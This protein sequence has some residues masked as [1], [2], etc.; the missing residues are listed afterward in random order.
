MVQAIR[1]LYGTL[2]HQKSDKGILV[3]TSGVTEGVIK[4]IKGKPL[5]ILDIDRILYL[6]EKGEKFTDW[7]WMAI[8]LLP[9]LP[10]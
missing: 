8:L 5:E 1:D 2:M 9:G 3:T 4:F 6:Q 10:L 7:S